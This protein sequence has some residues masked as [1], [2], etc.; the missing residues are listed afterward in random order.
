VAA[1]GPPGSALDARLGVPAPPPALPMVGR[2]RGRVTRGWVIAAGVLLATLVIGGAAL[3]AVLLPTAEIA[4]Q[5]VSQPV[6]PL[7][8]T[9]TAEPSAAAPD[10]AR[11]VVPAT[12]LEIPVSVK[13]QFAST[14][15]EVIEQKARGAVTFQNCDTGRT[16]SF[17]AGSTVKT[18][19]GTAFV[20]AA[21]VRLD[22]AK[23]NPAFACTAANVNVTALKA[24]PE[25]NVVAGAINQLPT[26][27]DPVVL[28]VVNRAPTSGGSRQE[29]LRV[30][31]ADVDAA[32]AALRTQ[33]GEAFTAKLAEPGLPPPGSV[34]VPQ[35]QRLGD[36]VPTP[37][38]AG[39]VGRELAGFELSLAAAGTALAVDPTPVTGLAEARIAA[40]VASGYRLVPG[41]ARTTVDP[42]AVSGGTVTF[43]VRVRAEQ[44]REIDV[45]ALV[46]QIRGRSIAA[47]RAILEPYGSVQISVWPDWVTAIPTMD[48]R[49][50]LVVVPAVSTPT[51]P[52]GTS[53]QSS[54]RGPTDRAAGLPW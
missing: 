45:A 1:A 8:L 38:P 12:A 21:T 14:G 5:P 28:S 40:A 23:I 43:A 34:L 7:A 4:V 19:D 41:S 30:L 50:R 22:R 2:G 20:T 39:L 33:L 18:A 27:F 49:V 3:A 9:V 35:T 13:G 24:G 29:L 53:P 36:A 15:K 51:A 31:Q 52:P 48:G 44:V 16:H 42:P 10:P 47:A 25:G 37:D 32:L 6:G 11:L 54:R 46:E 17:P 26:G